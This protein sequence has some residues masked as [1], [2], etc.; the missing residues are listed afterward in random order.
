[1]D[2]TPQGG[3]GGV[4]LYHEDEDIERPEPG[5]RSPEPGAG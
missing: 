5:A 1:M 4:S 3:A 2:D